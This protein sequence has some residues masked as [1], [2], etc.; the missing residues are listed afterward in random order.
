[1]ASKLFQISMKQHDCNYFFFLTYSLF[2]RLL[3]LKYYLGK[4]MQ[5]VALKILIYYLFATMEENI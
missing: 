4:D 3:M 5:Y 2:K 1:M